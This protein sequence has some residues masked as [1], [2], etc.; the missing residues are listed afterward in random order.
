MS[1]FERRRNVRRYL[2]LL[3]ALTT[4]GWGSAWAQS[5]DQYERILTNAYEP[6]GP[7]ATAIV[8]R[9]DSV[10]FLG[11]AGLADVELGVPLG[12]DMVFEIGSITKQFTAAAIMMLAE[13]GKLSTDDPLSKFL[14]DYPNGDAYTV[15]HLLTHTSGIVSYT[16]IPEYM[17]TK[18]RQDMTPDEIIDEFDHLPVE[19]EPGERFAYNNSG[20][21]LLG[22]IIEE[23]SGESY[24]DYVEEHIFAKL[25]MAS[26][27]YGHR[28]EIIPRRAEGYRGTAG[29]YANA[30]YLSMTQPYAAGSLMMNVADWHRWSRA[31]FGGHVIS[32]EAV[33]RMSTPYVLDDGDTTQY[34]YGLG[35]GDIRDRPVVQHGGGIFGYSTSG[36]YVPDDEIFVAVFSNNPNAGMNGITAIRLAAAALGEPFPMPEAVA[37]DPAVHGRYEGLYEMEDSVEMSVWIEDGALYTQRAGQPRRQAT[38]ASDTEFF[39][40]RALLNVEFVVEN[41]AVTGMVVHTAD[42]TMRAE[43]VGDV[44]ATKRDVSVSVEILE[45][46]VGVYVV[47]EGFELTISREQDGLRAVATGQGGIE[48]QARSE[49]EFFNSQIGVDIEFVVE[50][51][52]AVALIV[53]QGAQE[54]RAEKKND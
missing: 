28:D 43:R 20:Y 23:V 24:E 40:K 15:E 33:E 14:P 21:I 48:L 38:P 1:F 3:L 11:A 53:R 45:R 37:F 2:S 42:E 18:V 44:P 12:P 13:E 41:D 22:A 35:V 9:G 34:G 25:G 50:N 4:L 5:T 26:A 30:Q 10:L 36:Y 51:G 6:D 7:G 8:A 46:Y 47:R 32:P 49:T 31:L 29:S 17:R 54:I 16:G 19:F 52:Q 39:Y 27:R